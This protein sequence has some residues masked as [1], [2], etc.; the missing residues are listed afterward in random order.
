MLAWAYQAAGKIKPAIELLE[1]VVAV[2]ER[3]LD[4]EHPA[5]VVSQH[6]LA[7]AYKADGQAKDAVDILKYV[8][9]VRVRTLDEAHPARVLSERVLEESRRQYLGF[10]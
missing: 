6:E 7:V 4:E 10:G 1:C 5:L 2:R 8:V 9:A 3:I